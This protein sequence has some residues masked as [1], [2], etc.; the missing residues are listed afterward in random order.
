MIIAPTMSIDTLACKLQISP[1]GNKKAPL[2]E[3]DFR[4]IE[5]TLDYCFFCHDKKHFYVVKGH[6]CSL[7]LSNIID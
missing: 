1:P 6:F 4:K 5:M 2:S 3:R 7:L